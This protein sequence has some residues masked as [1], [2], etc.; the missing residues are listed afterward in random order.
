MSDA[1]VAKR[2]TAATVIGIL[3]IIFGGLGIISGLSAVLCAAAVSSYAGAAAGALSDLASTYGTDVATGAATAAIAGAGTLTLILSILGLLLA[4]ALLIGGIG[5]LVNKK[6]GT[7]FTIIYACGTLLVTI[8]QIALTPFGFGFF[9]I[10]GL[11]YPI[12]A[13]VFMMMPAVKTYYA[14][15]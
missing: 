4:V 14:D 15:K 3:N 11:A 2:P 13:F 1:S 6:M 10:I 9:A 7:L 12:V 5:L 8:L